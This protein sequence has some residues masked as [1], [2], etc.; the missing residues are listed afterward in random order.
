MNK[1]LLSVMSSLSL[2]GISSVLGF[3]D[4]PTE[5][6]LSILA[7]SLGFA[8]V[9]IDKISKFKGAGFEAEIREQHVAEAVVTAQTDEI[10]RLKSIAFEID[11][12][13]QIIMNSLLRT[14]YNFRYIG[15]VSADTGLTKEVVRDELAWLK[16]KD[17]VSKRSGRN[18]Y[19]WNLT[20]KGMAVLPIVIF[21]R[22]NL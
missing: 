18:G 19:L 6:G 22:S 10:D 12:R 1:T 21:G 8:F 13:R 17:L 16:E 11:E 2:F 5:M 3:L 4:K 15:G 14:D 20:E 9:N 7:G